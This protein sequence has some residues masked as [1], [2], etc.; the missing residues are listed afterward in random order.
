MGGFHKIGVPPHHPKIRSLYYWNLWWLEYPPFS[1]NS[2]C[3]YIRMR[4]MA[5]S[6][7]PCIWGWIID[8]VVKLQGPKALTCLIR[9]HVF[10]SES[11]G[12]HIN[13]PWFRVFNCHLRQRIFFWTAH[14]NKKHHKIRSLRNF[15]RAHLGHWRYQ[16]SSCWLEPATIWGPSLESLSWIISSLVMVVLVVLTN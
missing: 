6:F 2:P 4:C 8:L 14:A 15:H 12:E 1:S 7:L 3:Y 5:A 11:L 9:T 16:R 13:V 10:F